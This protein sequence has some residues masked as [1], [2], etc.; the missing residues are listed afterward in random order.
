MLSSLLVAAALTVGQVTGPAQVA[1]G[2]LIV[3]EGP[4]GGGWLVM[5]PVDKVAREFETGRYFVL[6]AG[7]TPGTT[8]TV[9]NFRWTG[10]R[11]VVERHAVLVGP[12]P[13]PNPN[14][15]PNPNPTPVPPGD[16]WP[17]VVDAVR[18]A[19][20]AVPADVAVAIRAIQENYAT[21][22]AVTAALPADTFD[23]R[24]TTEQLRAKNNATLPEAIRRS[25]SYRIWNDAMVAAARAH[26]ADGSTKDGFCRWLRSV[27][28]GLTP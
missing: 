17:D 19:T 9:A 11:V 1:P 10:E 3:L 13:G 7:T 24:K 8:I 25:P 5:S 22:L 20:A 12:G 15:N 27:I 26:D 6:G 16:V 14:P 18:R 28:A 21:T 23:V 4:S 2:E